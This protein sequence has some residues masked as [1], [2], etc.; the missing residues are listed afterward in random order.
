MRNY[1]VAGELALTTSQKGFNLYQANRPGSRGPVPFATTSPFEQG[2]Q[3]TIEA[4]RRLGEKLSPK[5]ASS[6]WTHETK[7]IAIQD[8]VGFMWN[9]ARKTLYF[10]Q[11]FQL[12]DHYNI[13]FMSQFVLFFR[14]PFFTFNLILPFGMAGMAVNLFRSRKSLVSGLIFSSYASTL[15][16]FFTVTR[17]RLPLLIILIV[18]AVMG[19]A[20]LL[21]YARKKQLSQIGVYSAILV[22]F[23]VIESLPTRRQ[24]DVTAY[25]NTHAIILNSKGLG[26]EAVEYWKK[27]SEMKGQYSAFANLSLAGKYA[28]RE[29]IERADYYLTR[30]HDDSFAAAQKYSL[31]GD[32]MIREKR[33]KDAISAYEKSLQINSGQR[34]VRQRLV[35]IFSKIDKRRAVAEYEKLRYVSSFYDIL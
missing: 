33:I 20:D 19:M 7:K 2:I 15:I 32:I 13:D 28:G 11:Q 23:I 34:G 4:S 1:H 12:T 29:D 30:I 17:Y 27:S 6:Y 8:P 21:S 5:E 18:F 24:G 16:I 9:L 3:F 26:G 14:I 22:A 35:K 31:I 25:L 10:F